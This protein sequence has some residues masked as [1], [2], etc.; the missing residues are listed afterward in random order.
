M[1]RKSVFIMVFVCLLATICP[2]GMPPAQWWDYQY[3][4]NAS[5]GDA[6]W[7]NPANWDVQN[8]AGGI[9]N[10]PEPNSRTCILPNQP[11]PRLG[12]ADRT[13]ATAYMLDM[14]PWNP[15]GWGGQ[16]CNVTVMATAGNIN[17]GSVIRI[18]SEVDYDS[19]I[20]TNYLANRAILN[21]FGGTVTTPGPYINSTDL[22]GLHIGGGNPATGSVALAYGMLNIY[23]GLVEV[24]R[25]ELHYGEI[26]L[27]G[28]TLHLSADGNFVFST[29]HP[30]ATLN[31]IRIN[32]G[33]LI[34]D[35][36]YLNPD[37]NTHGGLNLP[38]LIV[39]GYVV[40]D[41]GTLGTPTY[42][43]GPNR[44]TL[45]ADVNY[46]AWKPQ[47]AN[48]AT[49]IHYKR[50]GTSDPC[51][52]TLSWAPSTLDDADVNHD[53][54]FGVNSSSVYLATKASPEYKG[55]RY[56]FPHY[57]VDANGDPCSWT[58]K[59]PNAFAVGAI[60][61]WRVDEIDTSNVV[62]K[63]L[64]W[65]FTAH[66]GWAY[67]HKPINKANAL[68]QP[69]QLSWAAGDFANSRRVYFSTSEPVGIATSDANVYRGTQSGT[70]YDL[71]NLAP[72]YTLSPGVTYY[73]RIVEV[74]T[75]YNTQW[76]G[77]TV[78]F[79]PNQYTNIDDFEDS[80]STDDVNNNWAA[81]YI[82]TGNSPPLDY[83]CVPSLTGD[84][85][86][87][88]M[89]TATGKYLR[90]GYRGGSGARRFS[91]ARRPYVGGVSFTGGGVIYPP[92][93]ALNIDYQGSALNAA[94][95]IS[96][97]MYVAIEDTA[98][99]VAIYDNPDGNAAKVPVWTTWYTILADINALGLPNPV[100]LEAV[101]GIAIGF[102]VR[103][104]D[105]IAA[106]DGNVMFDNI[107]LYASK[108]V[109]EFG[110]KADLDED[111]DVDIN[112]MDRLSNEWLLKAETL[113]Y[114]VT[115]TTKPPIIWYKF[116]IDTQG[117]ADVCDSGTGDAN[118]YTGT[119]QRFIT[120]NWDPNGGRDGNGCLFLPSGGVMNW[121]TSPYV[122]IPLN[123]LNY[124]SDPG[125]KGT[126]FS[127]WINADLYATEFYN[128]GQWNSLIEI[129]IS[130][131]GVTRTGPNEKMVTY[132]P[133]PTTGGM[134]AGI[135]AKVNSQTGLPNAGPGTGNIS[136]GNF[137][138]KWNHWAFVKEPMSMK[139]YVNGVLLA[140]Q[141]ANGDP[142]DPNRGA[143]GP[144]IVPPVPLPTG[145]GWVQGLD[146]FMLGE[147]GGNSWFN[148]GNWV[149][150]I[151][152]FQLYDYALTAAEVEWL[153]TDSTCA[154]CT[155]SIYV[156]LVST[157]NIKLDGVNGN[158]LDPNQIVNFGDMAIMENEW[159]TLLLYP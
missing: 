49:N 111:C 17:F 94:D 135:W 65:K 82:P 141:D 6:N 18:N 153:A 10:G 129:V 30:E 86:R 156:P 147:R 88:L 93:K 87:I 134:A 54:Y 35:G 83:T 70:T 99:N 1:F 149:G 106:G 55:T 19:Y 41:R 114:T 72:T 90:Y 33:T 51:S 145:P 69:L 108:C 24:P 133:N 118:N 50:T 5:A 28:G 103:C 2:A 105:W 78:S 104:N 29:T 68:S 73:W 16:D 37:T 71:K 42:A 15:T 57:G 84:S 46:C 64:I 27:N 151:D 144:L 8:I 80:L 7:Y 62:K 25:L 20:G 63:G 159:H 13:D 101:S 91:E 157:A 132:V 143:S 154:S 14:N 146:A 34:L 67:N 138:G 59:E 79:T 96:D 122:D 3:E 43:A 76:V 142:C 45:T 81:P 75:T 121:S 48:N 38:A 9:P 36:N 100:N 92:S 123:S 23:G 125:P 150:R 158:Q 47:P 113:T 136:L 85:S 22:C 77:D 119:I 152:D 40:C 112:D 66:N 139:I 21:V 89:R 126:T 124:L 31:K 60:Y 115:K 32:G 12:W 117:T 130:P 127:I 137:G 109:P 74:N 110:P 102:G 58:I 140:H 116:N 148:W 98:G 26:G 97:R 11:G 131:D 52:V 107:R 53:V 128:P 56:D 39:G 120:E 95:T 61:Y 44:T 155:A 4:W